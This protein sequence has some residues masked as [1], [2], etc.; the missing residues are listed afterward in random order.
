MLVLLSDFRE[1]LPICSEPPLAASDSVRSTAC[2]CTC[3][4]ACVCVHVRMHVMHVCISRAFLLK[5]TVI[6]CLARIFS[7]PL[8]GAPSGS[9]ET[10]KTLTDRQD[11]QSLGLSCAVPT[12]SQFTQSLDPLT[13]STSMWSFFRAPFQELGMDQGAWG[14]T[15]LPSYHSVGWRQ[16]SSLRVRDE[17]KRDNTDKKDVQVLRGL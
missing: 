14:R 7:D 8:E 1:W 5:H 6:N 12:G 3:V 4:Y 16:N 9:H 2:V 15:P 10:V 11:N 17:S 13:H